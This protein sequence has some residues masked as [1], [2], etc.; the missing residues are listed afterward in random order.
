MICLKGLKC[1]KC[2]KA[3]IKIVIKNMFS[4]INIVLL[5]QFRIFQSPQSGSPDRK[6]VQ[7]ALFIHKSPISDPNFASQS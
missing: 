6:T 4:S 2:L 1:K 5:D 7:K 3:V